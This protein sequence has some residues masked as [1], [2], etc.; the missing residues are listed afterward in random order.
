MFRRTLLLALCTLALASIA[1]SVRSTLPNPIISPN[2]S[3][4][5]STHSTSG[6][7][8]VSTPFF[9]SL[10]TNGRTCNSCH[11]S[12]TAWTISPAE[13]QSRF[14]S[15]NGTDPIFRTNDGANCPSA[16]VSTVAA[17]KGAYSLLLN[18][19][20]IRISL[21]VPATADF[22]ITD[23]QDPYS[24]AQTTTSQPAM[25]RR[26]LPSTNIPFLTTVMWDG[27]ESP[28]GRSL[29]ANLTQQAI[30]ATSGHAQ[31][32]V[33][34][35]P[36]QLQQIVDFETALYT[37]QSSDNAAGVHPA[38]LETIARAT[39]REASSA[40][41]PRT[42]ANTAQ[43]SGLR[44]CADSRSKTS[45]DT[46]PLSRCRRTLFKNP[47]QKALSPRTPP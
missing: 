12:T 5:L 3:G 30:D 17:R 38:I 15:T 9:Q 37:A 36:T 24:C 27:R 18:K 39:P 40:S 44:K 10:G 33:T 45:A 8:D 1:L 29:E 41:V 47:R 16:D 34:P 35:N 7:I 14:K 28:K 22:E 19:G 32:A 31:G 25:Y 4:T 21:P 13:V 20:L 26:P 6:S 23:I 46:V 43:E 11:V 42:S 2:E